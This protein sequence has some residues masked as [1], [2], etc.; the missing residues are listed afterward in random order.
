MGER[1]SGRRE[2]ERRQLTNDGLGSAAGGHPGLRGDGARGRAV[3]WAMAQGSDADCRWA[4]P[5]GQWSQGSH[6]GRF[7]RSGARRL[8]RVTESEQG[9]AWRD[10]AR[11]LRL[12]EGR[13]AFV[14]RR[15]SEVMGLKGRTTRGWADR[16][17][18]WNT[19]TLGVPRSPDQRSWKIG[20]DRLR[21]R[22]SACRGARWP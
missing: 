19:G 20:R 10:H 12:G 17:V 1:R 5:I 18:I 16:R 15:R 14:R 21:K 6:G 7:D 11:A 9:R 4:A 2:A 8:G 3:R 13:T 22:A